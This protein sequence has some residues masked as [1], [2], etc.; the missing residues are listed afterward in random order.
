MNVIAKS[1]LLEAAEKLGPAAVAQAK[2]WYH[3]A[4]RAEWRTFQD[5]RQKYKDADL[6]EGETVVFNICWNRF[7]LVVRVWFSGQEIYIKFFGT[8]ADYERL[9]LKELR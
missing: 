2:A 4:S 3:E 7:R 6:V 5:I 1:T 8:H 9:N